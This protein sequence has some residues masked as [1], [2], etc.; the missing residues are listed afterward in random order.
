MSAPEYKFHPLADLF[1]QMQGAEFDELVADIKAHGLREDIVLYDGMI[2]D[3]RNRCR[4]CLAAGWTWDAIDQV[5][6]DLGDMG[7]IHDPAAYVISANIHRRP[8]TA[9]QKREL[10]EKLLKATPEKPDRQIAKIAKVSPT[11]VGTK[12]AKMEKTGDV[13]KL[14]TRQ[15]TKGRKQPANK[16]PAKV[17]AL[18]AKVQREL[19]AKDA[20]INELETARE[21]DNN[22]AEQL[23]AARI[24]IIGLESEIDELKAENAELRSQLEAARRSAGAVTAGD[25]G[26]IPDILRRG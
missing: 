15:D 14:D 20:H 7:L 11:T 17:V 21:R 18:P 5:C 26:P 2:L 19:D 3:G 10:V 13:S 24:K 22:L 25:P 1:P 6:S 23:Q 16:K 12:R 4:A 9:E 8:L